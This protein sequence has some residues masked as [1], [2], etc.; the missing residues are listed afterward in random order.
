MAV[1]GS[2]RSCQMSQATNN[3]TP[4]GKNARAAE[5]TPK[6]ARSMSPEGNNANRAQAVHVSQTALRSPMLTNTA[7]LADGAIRP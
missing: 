4:K 3:T 7:Q 1:F 6:T 2:P 5:K